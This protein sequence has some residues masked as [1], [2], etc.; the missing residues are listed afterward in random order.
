MYPGCYR[1]LFFFF[2]NSEKNK[3]MVSTNGS[4]SASEDSDLDV[5]TNQ[6]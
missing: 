4:N 5:S 2:W 1:G 6:L 3:A